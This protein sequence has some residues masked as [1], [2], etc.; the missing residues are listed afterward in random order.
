[1]LNIFIGSLSTKKNNN[2]G[3]RQKSTL[4]YQEL[5]KI[6][7][8]LVC[9]NLE[10]NHFISV[11]RMAAICIFKSKRINSIVI[12]KF[13]K[14]G[15]LLHR[16]L[17]FFRVDGRKITYFLV[18][19]RLY[20]FLNEKNLKYVKN[21]KRIVVESPTIRNELL[22][23]FPFLKI[24]VLSN[25]KKIYPLFLKEKTYPKKQLNAVFFSRLLID[26]GIIDLIDALKK[27]NKDSIKIILDIY[28]P[29]SEDKNEQQVIYKAIKD[30]KLFCSYKGNLNMPCEQSYLTLSDYDFH[31]FPT[32]FPE[33]IPGTLIDCLNCGLPTLSSSFPRYKDILDET[34]SFIFQQFNN[35]DLISKLEYIYKNQSELK[36]KSINSYKKAR[37]FSSDIFVDYIKQNRII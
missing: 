24:D 15:I 21:D 14:G 3:E 28:G 2:G 5:A 8:N 37:N 18:G 7:N 34:D 13:A 9:I 10:K 20:E 27:I 33:G 17:H 25:F 4:M 1:M 23:K 16:I 11:L 29:E 26:K 19:S 36:E 30:N 31:I 35:K 6:D 12:S 32:R 22:N